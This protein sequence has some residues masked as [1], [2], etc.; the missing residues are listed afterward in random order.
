MQKQSTE[1]PDLFSLPVNRL[2]RKGQHTSK[3]A[4]EKSKRSRSNRTQKV[5]NALKS[6]GEKGAIPEEMVYYVSE[7]LIDVRRC[8]HVLKK[9]GLI[10]PTGEQRLNG[11]GNFCEVFKVKE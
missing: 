7:D 8:F 4:L 5:Y 3:A 11:K 2:H 1:Q 6:Y 9:R 10:V